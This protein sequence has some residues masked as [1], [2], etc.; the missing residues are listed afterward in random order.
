MLGRQQIAGIP[1]AISELFKNAHDAYAR[2]VEVDYFR[3]D[4]LFVLRDDGLGMSRDDFEQRWLTLGTESKLGEKGGLLPPPKDKT[5][6][7][8]PILG[9]KGIGRLAI[10]II[11]PQVFVLTRAKRDRHPSDVTVGAYL[12]WGLFELPGLDLEDILIPIREI[13][14]GTLPDQ[15]L[16]LE[17]VDE[18][19]SS[20]NKIYSRT[21]EKRLTKIKKEMFDFDINP[22]DIDSYLNNPSLTGDG[23]GTHFFIK[24]ADSIIQH[25]IDA[26]EDERKA[27][28]FEKHLLGFTNT[29]TPGSKPPP[30]IAR[31]RDHRDEGTPTELIGETAFF[32]P[33]EYEEV[34]HHISGRFDQLGQFR[35]K[36]GIYQSTP[37]D[38][39]LNWLESDGNPTLC[40]PF[41][42]SIA[43]IQAAARDSLVTPEEHAR[44]IRKS[45]RHG[46]LY[47]YRDGVRIQPYGDSDYDWLDIERRRTLSAGYYYYSF[48]RMFGAI[49]L[50]RAEN[51]DLIEKAGREGF[52]ENK[53]YRQ[54]RSILMN[55]FIQTAADFFREDGKYAE[56]WDEKKQQL[57]RND[58]IRRKKAKQ[59]TRRRNQFE[60]NLNRFFEQVDTR[61]P[62]VTAQKALAEVKQKADRILRAG[63]KPPQKAAA[64]MRIEKEGR[65]VLRELRSTLVVAKP[66]GIGLSRNL[67]NEWIAYSAEMEKVENSVLLPTEA[68]IEKFITSSAKKAKLPINHIARI[69]AAVHETT[70]K[71]VRTVRRLK[72]ENE[73]AFSDIAKQVR[74]TT[75]G[76]LKAV[77]H[78]V[79][80]VMAELD[81]LKKSSTDVDAL[82]SKREELEDQI[83]AVFEIERNRL[84]RLQEQFHALSGFWEEDGYDTTELTE[85][86]EEELVILRE[87]RD[88]DL[89]MAQIGLALNT[90]NHEFEK[91]V[92]ALRDGFRRLKSWATANPKLEKLYNDM[93]YSFDHLDGYLTLFT[94]L[95]RRLQRQAIDISGQDIFDFLMGLFEARLERHNVDLTATP[96][97]RKSTVHGYPSSFYPVYVNLVDNAIFWQQRNHNKK[98]EIVLDVEGSDFLISDNGPGVSARDRDNIFLL[99]FSRKPGGRGMGLYISRESLSKVGYDLTLDKKINTDGATFRISPA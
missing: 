82:S 45:N 42:F 56:A 76:S 47:I 78:V 91:T 85:A 31:F 8:R 52:S 35:G 71:A 5:Q 89:E 17:M 92:G 29:M 70:E 83:E 10:A 16:V 96:A 97:Y 72:K 9:E 3:D 58:V 41:S 14:G 38:Y 34:D 68:E 60:E 51:G 67:S 62:E 22:R 19:S 20:F 24:P 37:D 33:N 77:N 25:D 18:V 49:E 28:R 53:A 44:M 55:F 87:Q 57:N 26:R 12:H 90:I 69:D 65:D 50:S 27:T 79:D 73:D 46:G 66:R 80:E 84:E 95:D 81:R 7:L 48:R 23:C 99:N 74:E 88:V 61:A 15:N 94:P 40:G 59:V 2:N 98:R 6:S 32:S 63:S 86:L 4:G 64:L 75:K 21:D 11:G 13:K 39:V 30:I 36:V 54:F 93:R 1:T 43:V